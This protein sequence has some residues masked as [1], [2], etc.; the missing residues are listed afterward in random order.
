MKLT[1]KN[2]IIG[3]QVGAGS[4]N[5]ITVRENLGEIK[6]LITRKMEIEGGIKNKLGK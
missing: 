6:Y 4:F 3:I 1:T 2:P 5:D